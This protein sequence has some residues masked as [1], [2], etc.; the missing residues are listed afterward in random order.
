MFRETIIPG[1]LGRL[2]VI[3]AET[4]VGAAARSHHNRAD[5]A[6][7]AASRARTSVHY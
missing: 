5:L 3:M 1:F 6:D 7:V 2:H 4:V